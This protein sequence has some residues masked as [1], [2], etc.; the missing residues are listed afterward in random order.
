MHKFVVDFVGWED[1]IEIRILKG[2]ELHD[3][4]RED[5][6]RL[7]GV[8]MQAWVSREMFMELGV[9]KARVSILQMRD[10]TLSVEKGVNKRIIFDFQYF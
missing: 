7:F 8:E 2:A 4:F 10:L 3:M 6:K 5:E 1:K 9:C